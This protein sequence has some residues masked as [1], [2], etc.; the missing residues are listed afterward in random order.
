[1]PLVSGLDYTDVVTVAVVAVIVTIAVRRS[2]EI[3]IE[4]ITRTLEQALAGDERVRTGIVRPDA[5]G[6]LAE[7]VDLVLAR[8]SAEI[9]ELAGRAEEVEEIGERTRV[10]LECGLKV[11]GQS[12]TSGVMAETIRGL[13]TL[14]PARRCYAWLDGPPDRKGRLWAA[15]FDRPVGEVGEEAPLFIRWAMA[16]GVVEYTNNID[17]DDRCDDW[18]Q[19][20]AG[21]GA[22]AGALFRGGRVAGGVALVGRPEGFAPDDVVSVTT[23]LRFTGVA[24]ERAND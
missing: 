5:V 16:K 6:R 21:E 13:L 17:Y 11:V 4:R 15:A 1:M 9:S 12:A 19:R 7:E 2:Y 18:N 24:L 10:V 20:Y 8:R 22:L 3:G 14:I 23:L